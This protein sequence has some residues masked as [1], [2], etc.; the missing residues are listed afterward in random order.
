[1][2]SVMCELYLLVSKPPLRPVT[3]GW[4]SYGL[5]EVLKEVLIRPYSAHVFYQ[6]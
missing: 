4:N 1:M 3:S 2:L 5:K 6:R